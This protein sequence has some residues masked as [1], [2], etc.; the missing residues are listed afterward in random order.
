MNKENQFII[1]ICKRYNYDNSNKILYHNLKLYFTIEEKFRWERNYDL[2]ST[3][4]VMHFK[5]F[6]TAPRTISC[7]IGWWKH[8]RTNKEI[9][10]HDSSGQAA[11]QAQILRRKG[12]T[13]R[14]TGNNWTFRMNGQD[15][16]EIIGFDPTFKEVDANWNKLNTKEKHIVKSIFNEDFLGISYNPK[17]GQFDHRIPQEVRRHEGINPVNLTTESLINGTWH[18]SFQIL[19]N[20]TNCMKREACKICLKGGEIRLPLS[21]ELFRSAYRKTFNENTETC[22][23]CFWFNHLEPKNKNKC[24]DLLFVK[25]KEQNKVNNVKEEIL[26]LEKKENHKKNVKNYPDLYKNNV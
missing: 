10:E 26:K 7:L 3:Y 19:S 5:D 15:F 8:P 9:A 23:G 11:K 14:K 24:S 2:L 1:E 6:P 18:D 25:E 12:F 21:I 13:Q 4:D 17:D 20:K 16:R 22:S